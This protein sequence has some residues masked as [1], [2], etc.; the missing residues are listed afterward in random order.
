MAHRNRGPFSRLR[1]KVPE[2]RMGG[3]LTFS[4]MPLV[5]G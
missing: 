4:P 5:S 1:G 2:G 3:R